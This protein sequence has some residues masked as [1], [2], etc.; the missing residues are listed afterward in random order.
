MGDAKDTDT[1]RERLGARSILL[2]GMP[3]SG[4]T[5]IGRRLAQRLGLSFV[6]ADAEIEK[7]AGM[8]ITDIFT[9][10]GEP[11]F[12]AGEARVIAR[13]IDQGPQ[14]IAT[15]GGAFMNANTRALARARAIS[16]WLKAEVAVLLRRVKRKSDRPLLQNADPETTLRRLIAERE[17]SY[18]EAEIVVT[19]HEGP[20]ETVVEEIVAALKNHL[21]SSAVDAPSHGEARP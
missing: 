21:A 3:G 17:Q 1:L 7:A 2:V 11:E 6:D 16:V 19:S 15:G 20:H 4:K 9:T 5:S 8:S 13:L 14:V 18:A 12:R 10:R